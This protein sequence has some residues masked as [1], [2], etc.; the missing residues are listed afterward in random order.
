VTDHGLAMLAAGLAF[1]GGAIG[2]G[3]GNGV[4]GNASVAGVARQPEA[5]GRITTAL[6]PII[7]L[8]EGA[9]FINLALGFYLITR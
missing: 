7:A 1:G 4:V 8:V 3:I 2:A 5:G 6:F 9:Y